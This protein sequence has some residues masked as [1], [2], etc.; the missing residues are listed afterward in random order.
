M[1]FQRKAGGGIRDALEIIAASSS[2]WTGAVL[3]CKHS[4]WGRTWIEHVRVCFVV[5]SH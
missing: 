4:G 5:F 1:G 2:Q 3:I